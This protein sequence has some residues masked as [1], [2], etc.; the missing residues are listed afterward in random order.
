MIF[1]TLTSDIK[2]DIRVI[3]VR[4]RF[5]LSNQ[6]GM[7][8]KVKLLALPLN[9]NPISMSETEAVTVVSHGKTKDAAENDAENGPSCGSSSSG[10][11]HV[12]HPLLQWTTAVSRSEDSNDHISG[13]EEQEK[14]F[15]CYVSFS[16][17]D[18]DV[19]RQVE[20]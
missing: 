1:I 2:H 10:S 14:T 20:L 6:T 11:S 17:V 16:A 9:P 8:L 7:S 4:E 3:C 18:K 12:P 15:V 19:G 5:A 13:S